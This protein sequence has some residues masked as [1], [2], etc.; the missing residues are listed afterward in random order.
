MELGEGTTLTHSLYTQRGLQAAGCGG[1]GRR[2]AA[3]GGDGRRRRQW[4]M[5]GR[6]G[7]VLLVRSQRKG[8]R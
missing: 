4:G 6:E 8:A 3:M 7:D 2:W 1:D 5:Q